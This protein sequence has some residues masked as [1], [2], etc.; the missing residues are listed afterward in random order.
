MITE[1]G[2]VGLFFLFGI[3]F[4]ASAFIVSW[5]LRPSDPSRMKNS[6]YEC[7]EIVK[8]DSWIQFNVQYY[9]IALIF[10][11]FDIEVLFLVPWAVVFR[12]LGVVAYY[13]MVLFVFILAFGLVYAWK[14][15]A[16]EWR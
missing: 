5:L 3:G 10:V 14:K 6:P 2:Y 11:I 1:Y 16:F 12:K 13:E 15:G 9:L 4:V 8:G 7:G